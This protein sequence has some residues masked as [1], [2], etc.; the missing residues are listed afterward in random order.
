MAKAKKKKATK[1]PHTIINGKK[2]LIPG[3][4]HHKASDQAYVKIDGRRIYLGKWDTPEAEAAYQARIADWRGGGGAMPIPVEDITVIEIVARYWQHCLT[5]Y[6]GRDGRGT[7]ELDRIEAALN[8]LKAGYGVIPAAEF[9]PLKLRAYQ[10]SLISDKRCRGTVNAYTNLVR[11]CFKWA[12]SMQ[13]IPAPVYGALLTVEG[14]KA[15]RSTARESESVLPAIPADV[16]KTLKHLPGPLQALVELQ[17]LTA[18]R[19]AE[20]LALKP[21]DIDTTGAVWVAVLAHHKTR[22]H[23]K[24]RALYFGP[25][26]QKILRLF[27]L[28][29]RDSFLFSPKESFQ[30]ALR[31]DAQGA[32]RKPNQKPSPR[33]TDR[34][35]GDCYTT[36]SYARAIA[37]ACL[38]AGVPAWTPNQLRHLA[39]TKIRKQFGL[40]AA[41]SVLGHSRADVTQIYAELARLPQL[42]L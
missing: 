5:Y 18:A 29:D 32:G 6:K 27:L 25:K 19:P 15:E 26:A 42:I 38:K 23:G 33:K 31:R 34:T 35:M 21:A 17:E 13:L 40:D 12:A 37:R 3:M 24:E 14:L 9:T 41:Q 30:E 7:S 8:P 1:R 2:R 28:R 16:K 20:L 22:H 36:H 10:Q 39:A 4:C 11:R